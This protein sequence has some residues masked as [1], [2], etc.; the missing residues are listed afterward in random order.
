MHSRSV[1]HPLLMWVGKGLGWVGV[2]RIYRGDICPEGSIHR[3][4]LISKFICFNNARECAR[5]GTR[6]ASDLIV[7]RYRLLMVVIEGGFLID[8]SDIV[9]GTD[10]QVLEGNVVVFSVL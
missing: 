3:S 7:R 9:V 4:W 8:S 1:R 5:S 6:C 2:W 10:V